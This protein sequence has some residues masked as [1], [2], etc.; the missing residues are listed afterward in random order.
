MKYL[1]IFFLSCFFACKNNG[2]QTDKVVDA[3]VIILTDTIPVLRTT[4]QKEP[5]ASHEQKVPD[6]LNDWQFAV[7]VY[8]TK[9]RFHYI[10]RMQYKELRVTDSLTVPNIGIEPTIQIEKDKE[11]FSCTLGFPD[12]K[13]NFKPLY[14]ASVKGD[15]LR[16]KTVASYAVGV[17]RTE[18]K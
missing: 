5:V 14:R 3:K 4:V 6:E 2:N 11:P 13:G 16:F 10:V 1:F 18:A 15:R 7:N 12:K 8:E 9:R 17:Y